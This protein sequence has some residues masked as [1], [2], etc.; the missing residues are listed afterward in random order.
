[1]SPIKEQSELYHTSQDIQGE[2]MLILRETKEFD[3]D[4]A[5]HHMIGDKNY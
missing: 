1:V 3:F 5:Y 2:S 4:C